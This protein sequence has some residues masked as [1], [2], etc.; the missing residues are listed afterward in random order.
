VGGRE[1]RELLG[2]AQFVWGVE[3]KQM[4]GGGDTLVN[5]AVEFDQ[6]VCPVQ[7]I[8]SAHTGRLCPIPQLKIATDTVTLEF[9]SSDDPVVRTKRI[10]VMNRLVRLKW[11]TE[12]LSHHPTVF[13]YGSESGCVRMANTRNDSVPHLSGIPI[14]VLRL[15]GN[16]C[17]DHR[18]PVNANTSRM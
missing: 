17:F 5:R 10:L 2:F 14:T 13:E 15:D 6:T 4:N 18:V 11:T 12:R 3:R 8:A 1:G 16:R 9:V 7:R